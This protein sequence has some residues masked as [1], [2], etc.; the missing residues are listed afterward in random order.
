MDSGDLGTPKLHELIHARKGRLTYGDLA[1]KGGGPVESRWQQLGSASAMK[2]SPSL[3]NIKGIAEGLR[4]PEAIVWDA[5]GRSI[6]V[7]IPARDASSPHSDLWVR[8]PTGTEK[9]T[10]T[11]IDLL[12]ALVE[13]FLHQLDLIAELNGTKPGSTVRRLKA[14]RRTTGTES[15]GPRGGTRGT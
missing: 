14:A 11:Q 3:D 10:E 15:R 9:L 12:V 2:S 8:M 13:E 5:V 7:S 4:I 1:A 6:G